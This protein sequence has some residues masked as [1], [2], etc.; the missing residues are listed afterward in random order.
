MTSDQLRKALHELDG[1]RDLCVAFD[2]ARP[3]VIRGALLI[4]Q[5]EDGV[6]KVTDGSRV[7]MLDA[8]RV[9]WVV[10]GNGV[11]PEVLR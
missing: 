6:V 5:E 2:H 9:A 4:P 3:C 11:G 8:H 10:I 1:H 7:F